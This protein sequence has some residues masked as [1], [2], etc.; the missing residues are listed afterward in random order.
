MKSIGFVA[1]LAFAILLILAGVNHFTETSSLV[2]KV[3]D[4]FPVKEVF[5]YL[6]GLA[7]VASGVALAINKKAQLAMVLLGVMLILF[8]VLVWLPAGDSTSMGIFFRDLM[9]AACAWFMA[10]HVSD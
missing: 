5:V 4:Y 7:F 6:T 2:G 9:L 10:A 8:A 1:K 3:P